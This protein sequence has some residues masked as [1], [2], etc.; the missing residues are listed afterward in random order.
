MILGGL[1]IREALETGVWYVYI[2]NERIDYQKVKDLIGPNSI[3]MLLG[4]IIKVPISTNVPVDPTLTGNSITYH[5]TDLRE[6]P[7]V[8]HRGMFVLGS[9][10]HRINCNAILNHAQWVPMYDGRSTLGR[11]GLASHI[12]AGKGD[13]GFTG[14]FTLELVNHAPYPIVLSDKMRIGQ[15]LF[16]QCLHPFAYAGAYKDDR[17]PVPHTAEIGE[18]RV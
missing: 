9:C 11:L 12:T 8:L 13:Y 6:Q 3:D 1:A 14:T 2:G 5:E 16:H 10:L 18:G 4:P 7:C 17:D 15:L